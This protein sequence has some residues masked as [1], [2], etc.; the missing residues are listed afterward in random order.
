M[1]SLRA[2]T[3][4]L[5]VDHR[6]SPGIRPED[7]AHVPGLVAVGAGQHYERDTK[8]CTHCQRT[9]VLEP[10][11]T[12]ERG[13]CPKCYHYICDHCEAIRVK[14][15][16]CVP[17]AQVMDLALERAVLYENQL[18]HPDAVHSVDEL[19]DDAQTVTQVAV[20]AKEN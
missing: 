19:V 2:R 6:N 11:R 15:G 7:V 18:D 10:L 16:A 12:R 4:Y 3:G 17:M 9:I 1:S 20:T 13:Y 8:Q 5:E 14:S